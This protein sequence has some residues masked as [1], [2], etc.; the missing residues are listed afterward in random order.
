MDADYDFNFCFPV[1]KLENS[2]IRLS[3]FVVWHFLLIIA[4]TLT[5]TD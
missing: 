1:R 3:P 5:D 2:R 4:C